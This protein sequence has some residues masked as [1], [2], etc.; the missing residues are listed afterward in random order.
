MVLALPSGCS[1]TM[2]SAVPAARSAVIRSAA[3]RASLSPITAGPARM[4]A[5]AIPLDLNSHT[6]DVYPMKEKGDERPGGQLADQDHR[7]LSGQDPV[8]PPAH[9]L[10]RDR[11]RLAHVGS[12][13]SARPALREQFL[14]SR[15]S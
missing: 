13:M 1:V 5:E 9:P 10:T 15:L 12:P 3:P 11:A 8:P 14:S 2:M 7:R 6:S 4:T